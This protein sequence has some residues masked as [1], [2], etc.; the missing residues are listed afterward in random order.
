MCCGSFCDRSIFHHDHISYLLEF[1]QKIANF[2]WI[3][4]NWIVILPDLAGFDLSLCI[5]LVGSGGSDFGEGNLPL[6]LLASILRG[7]DPL[8]T[9]GS[10]ELGGL[11]VDVVNLVVFGQAW[12]PL[13]LSNN[14]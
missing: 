7:R 6:D 10:F 9:N 4:P 8:P 5:S 1:G 12:T 3:S 13:L 14:G 2:G 11:R